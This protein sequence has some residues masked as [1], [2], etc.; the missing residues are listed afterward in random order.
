MTHPVRSPEL[1]KRSVL[2]KTRRPKKKERGER[3][4][5]GTRS[6]PAS[7]HARPN[8]R[9]RSKVRLRVLRRFAIAVGGLL[10]ALLV[11]YLV[12]SA[13][14][15]GKVHAGV[16][17][18]GF[19]L[20]GLTH[21]EAVAALDRQV[22][23]AEDNPVVL[24]SGT[25]SWK[26]LP[27]AV[28]VSIDVEGGVSAAMEVSRK[29]N[30]FVDLFRRI[31]LFIW[32]TD[33]S[34]SGTVNEAA[35]EEVITQVADKLDLPPVNAGLL[36][37]GS[38]VK[39]M[40]GQKGLMVDRQALRDGLKSLLFSLHAT[41]LQVPMAVREPDVM[42]DDFD[43]AIAKAKV[44]V[45][46]PV[47]LRE[48]EHLWTLTPDQ[49]A[50]YMDFRAEDRGGVSTLVPFLS[51]TKMR[52]FLDKV[53]EMVYVA[54]QDATFKGDGEKAWVIPA[55]AGKKLDAEKTA[56]SLTAAA[57]KP[58]GR[59]AKATVVSI[60]PA[61]TTEEAQAM[62]ITE[63]LASFTT[64]WVG[65]EDRQQN[66]R[67]ATQYVN[68]VLLA[69]GEVF[70]F[71]K[72]V[73]PRTEERGFRLAHG[74]VG[75]GRLEDVLGGGI[76][77][78]S[79]TLFNAAF[80]AGL[81]IIERVNHSI[82]ID[83][84]PLGR[85]ATVSANGPNLRFRNDT[86]HY[87]L[88]RGVSD[89]ITTKFVIYGTDEGRHVEFTTSEPYD[90]VERTEVTVKNTLLGVSTTSILSNGQPGMK[91]KVVRIVTGPDGE[92]IHKD[93]FISVWEMLPRK[94]EVG[95]LTTTTTK[96]PTTTTKSTTTTTKPP[97]TTEPVTTVSS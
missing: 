80:F 2:V 63:A 37:E 3:R 28:K 39:V 24:V 71:D 89:G 26:V 50:A 66:V 57:L 15:Y 10:A 61:L 11:A 81:E 17:V 18:A 19:D 73:G 43:E 42:A 72:Q 36:I 82:F 59:T 67:M 1:G 16:S 95:V 60:E 35:L 86:K 4:Q 34:L 33:L 75:P 88:I 46:K 55:V 9:T 8:G 32:G 84:Y 45:S 20:G 85:D 49:V 68:N 64:R 40:K 44:M 76:C 7:G 12:D 90:V 30:L 22:K 23:E 31:G 74:I 56:A 58:T 79:T 5:S 69:P 70:D 52:P 6:R 29:S 78:V 62:G 25:E 94:I 54:P 13:V 96:P 97:A 87:I 83:H 47:V 21:D 93:T 41:E 27:S 48:G 92:V 53:A 91:I 38:S 65:T 77:Q 14:Y 51:P